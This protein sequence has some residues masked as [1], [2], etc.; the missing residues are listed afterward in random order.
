VARGKQ[1]A[2]ERAGLISPYSDDGAGSASA[3]WAAPGAGG[4][5]EDKTKST[6]F[7]P[8]QQPQMSGFAVHA[9]AGEVDVTPGSAAVVSAAASALTYVGGGGLWR[10]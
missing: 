7:G 6:H 10:A 3:D 1:D 2:A 5:F 9:R 4:R 8:Q